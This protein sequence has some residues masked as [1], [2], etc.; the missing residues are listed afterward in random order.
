[1]KL[2]T[3]VAAAL[4]LVVSLPQTGFAASYASGLRD[5]GG[6]QVEFVLNE[7]AAD[8]SINL[9]VGGTLN[10]GSLTQG[11]HTFSLG[12]ASAYDIVVKDS[13][14]AGYNAIDQSAN[15]WAGFDR[16][17]GLAINNIPSSP[18]FGTIYVN[19]NRGLNGVNPITVGSRT[20]GNGI[21]SLTAD[22]VGVDLPTW[23]VPSDPN[24]P[25]LAKLPEPFASTFALGDNQGYK[26]SS[27]FYRIGMDDAGNLIASD[28]SN[29]PGQAGLAYISNDL[30]TGAYLFAPTADSAQ[31]TIGS[32]G[33]I[34]VDGSGPFYQHGS[35]NGEP[36]ARGT[37][38]VDL[39][40]SAM[41]ED[42]DADK[43]FTSDT[44][45]LNDG[46]AIWTWNFGSQTSGSTVRPELT[47]APG[48]L[49]TSTGQDK[50][51]SGVTFPSFSLN[52]AGTH[53]DGSPVFLDYNIGVTANAQYN[54]HFDKWYLSGARSNGDDSS[55]LVI[56]TPEGPGGDGRDIQVD[57]ASKQFSIDNGLDG[58]TDDEAVV[59][60]LGINDIF[61]QA[62]NVSFSPDNTVMYVQ[63][64]L[65]A[66][67][68]NPYLGLNSGLGA[69]ILA[70]PLDA[71]GIPVI[72][73][74]DNGTPGDTTDDF[75]TNIVPIDAGVAGSSGSYSQVK[76][77][78]AGNVYYTGNVNE[79][80]EYFSLGGSTVATT[81][82]AG[83]FSIEQLL[84]LEGDYNGDGL[85]NAADYTVWRDTLGS[86][87]DLRADGNGNLIVDGPAGAGS[88]Y[89]VWTSNYGAGAS[90]G[91]S[92]AIPEPTS[93]L[94]ATAAALGLLR[95]S[96]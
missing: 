35:I 51:T 57:W 95:R 72:D 86:T 62:H 21:Y 80:L 2:C 61:R 12:A 96:S 87:T 20:M 84:A 27:A 69:K 19:Q 66:G 24:D 85:V 3:I 63:R 40:V 10:L 47:I 79:S 31:T 50:N 73:V 74:D 91:A 41:D 76:T 17:G 94:L 25:A 1:M 33:K 88:D 83:T 42:L 89:E 45:G 5:I 38:G 30:T 37:Y 8:V 32:G 15:P 7:D 53:S 90:S 11:R 44:A 6:G 23:S 67:D 75:I 49:Y 34:Q 71:N 29:F 43:L 39:V 18:Y 58:Y 60:S 56:L 92:V 28:W 64:R 9:N 65:V 14:P 54:A 82:S 93:I 22:R 46:N 26:S 68:N 81:S 52:P 70:I 59:N 78:A 36:Q 16:P 77:D 4:G 48:D 13:A 55:N